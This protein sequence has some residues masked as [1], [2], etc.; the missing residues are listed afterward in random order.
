MLSG[1]QRKVTEAIVILNS[2]KAPSDKTHRLISRLPLIS[3]LFTKVFLM[4]VKPLTKK[5]N[6]ILYNQF[7]FR[8]G[9]II[10]I[11]TPSK[12]LLNHACD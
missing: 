10:V 11:I 4:Q 9:K 7:C 3:K 2:D 5:R 12:H 6:L 1:K 8:N